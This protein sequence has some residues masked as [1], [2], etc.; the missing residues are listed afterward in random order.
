M[1]KKTRINPRE[2]DQIAFKLAKGISISQI[3][4]DLNR[5]KSSV[6]DEIKRNS[7][8][9]IYVAIC[10]QHKSDNRKRLARYKNRQ[11]LKS[12]FIYSYTLDKLRYGWSPEQILGRL[13]LESGHSVICWETIYSFIHK[14]ENKDKRLWEHLTLKRRKREKK[15][16]RC[17][18]IKRIPNRVSVHLRDKNIDDRLEYGHWGYS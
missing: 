13:K 5:S 10:A 9:G 12:K 7:R 8:N 15:Q 11:S 14:P 6:S 2:R 17:V 16:N 4:K 1:K 3:A 18:Q